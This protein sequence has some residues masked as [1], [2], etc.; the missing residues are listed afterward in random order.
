MDFGRKHAVCWYQP[1]RTLWL[2]LGRG[3]RAHCA[4]SVLPC[5]GAC[6]CVY[7]C[8]R[9]LHATQVAVQFMWASDA[10]NGKPLGRHSCWRATW[11]CMWKIWT[12]HGVMQR[13]SVP[14]FAGRVTTWESD[15]L[16]W[17]FLCCFGISG[18]TFVQRQFVAKN[19]HDVS[20]PRSRTGSIRCF[21]LSEKLCTG[22]GEKPNGPPDSFSAELCV[23]WATQRSRGTKWPQKPHSRRAQGSTQSLGWEAHELRSTTQW[24]RR[25]SVSVGVWPSPTDRCSKQEIRQKLRKALLLGTCVLG[26]KNRQRSISE[27]S[28]ETQTAFAL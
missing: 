16:L 26:R 8:L 27:C 9:T 11:Q 13:H 21:L 17:A 22:A 20:F 5:G 25:T 15:I 4:A 2:V 14:A 18:R 24:A 3:A 6:V 7:P 10:C 23:W 1:G 19:C 12:G 28:S